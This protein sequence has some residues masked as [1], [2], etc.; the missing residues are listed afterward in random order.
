M[1]NGQAPFD[2]QKLLMKRLR[3]GL[4]QAAL[5]RRA[6]LDPSY[7]RLLE[8]GDRGPSPKTLGALAEVFGCDITDLMPDE[9]AA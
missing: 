2:R 4:S 3:A 1:N 7:I 8:R 5:A 9:V 6:E